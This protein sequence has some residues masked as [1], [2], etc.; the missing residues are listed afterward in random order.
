MKADSTDYGNGLPHRLMRQAIGILKLFCPG[1]LLQVLDQRQTV[2]MAVDRLVTN[3][4]AVTNI[5]DVIQIDNPDPG[6]QKITRASQ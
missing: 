4:Q 2:A 6:H 5:G 1:P 3:G